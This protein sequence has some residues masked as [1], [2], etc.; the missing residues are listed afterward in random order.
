MFDSSMKHLY[1]CIISFAE[2]MQ[3]VFKEAMARS[4]LKRSNYLLA[5]FPLLEQS[6][7]RQTK[8]NRAGTD[9]CSLLH[10]LF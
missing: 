5:N 9:A 4:F 3:V 8:K 6:R 10:N 1:L 7:G 2:K